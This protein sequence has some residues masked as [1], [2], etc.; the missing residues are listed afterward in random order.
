M[1]LWLAGVLNCT[2]VSSEYFWLFLIFRGIAGMGQASYASVC[3]SLISDMFHGKT[4]S[5]MYMLFS[6]ATTVGRIGLTFGAVTVVSGLMGT[7]IGTFLSGVIRQGRGVFRPAKTERGPA[8]V[9]VLGMLIAAPL[10]VLGAIFGHKSITALWILL[11]F[12]LT[13]CFLNSA[14]IMEIL[15]GVVAPWKRSTAFSYFILI[16]QFSGAISP[17]IVGAVSDAIRDETKTPETQ[18][19]SL[20]KS[21]SASFTMLLISG[22]LYTI[23]ATTI[24]KDQTK[25]KKEIG[26]ATVPLKAQTS[27]TEELNEAPG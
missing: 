12:G 7:T 1:T 24:V 27:S 3:P 14:L 5:H 16:T 13:S 10:L 17:Y 19:V 6:I 20:V 15:M 8:I 21:S 25:L 2:F 11:L 26:M 23:C 18:Y 22:V 9:S 4:R